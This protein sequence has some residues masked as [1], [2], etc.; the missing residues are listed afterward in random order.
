MARVANA[1]WSK[2]VLRTNLGI[3]GAAAYRQ[4][5]IEL[6]S[7]SA[8]DRTSVQRMASLA[9][10]T[11]Q[12]AATPVSGCAGLWRRVKTKLCSILALFGSFAIATHAVAA[13]L[14]L[15]LDQVP[16]FRVYS[17]NEGLNQKTVLAVEQD[18]DG[19]LWIATFGG[20]NRF[21]GSTFE[22]YTTRDGLRQNLIQGLLVDSSNRVWAGDAAGG[23]TVLENGRV[24]RVFEPDG[25]DRGVVRALEEVNGALYIALQP[26]GL[27]R[28]DLTELDGQIMRVAGA[29]NE[30]MALAY[31]PRDGFYLLSTDGLHRYDPTASQPFTHIDDDVST[32]SRDA[33]GNVFVGDANGRVGSVTGKGQ[34]A[35]FDR[36]FDARITGLI[37]RRGQV[38]WVFVDAL[39]MF[40][41]DDPEAAPYMVDSNGMSALY[42]QEGTL[43]V[44]G[45]QGLARYL[46]AR[47]KHYS[48]S[49]DG[50][51]PEVFSIVPDPQGGFWFGTNEGLIAVDA[52]GT[53]TN[54]S[55][56]LGVTRREVR[57]VVLSNDGETLW[58]GQI[59]GPT[60]AIDTT[61]REIRTTLGDENSLVV[62]ALVDADDRLWRGSYL[63]NLS[64]HDP[65]TGETKTHSISNG[66]AIYAMD[67][68]EDGVLWF[69]ASYQG[70]YRIDTR[71]AAAE[72]ELVLSVDKLEQEFFT[73]LVAE[74]S[75]EQ[76]VVWLAG[77][78][79]T[80]SRIENDVAESV[81]DDT[82]LSD[83][84]IYAI[85]PLPDDTIVLAT[86]RGA[87]R[88][89]S[90]RRTLEHYTSLDGFIAIEAKVHATYYDGGDN[91]LIGTTTGVTRMD[92][93]L[94]TAGVPVPTPLITRKAIGNQTD[95][96][97]ET[98]AAESDRGALPDADTIQV[99]YTA[100]SMRKPEAVVFSYRLQ[101]QDEE[102]SEATKTRSISYSNLQPGEYEFSVRA[103]IQG[104]TWSAPATWAFT[105]PTPFWR[106]PWFVVLAVAVFAMLV[107]TGIQWRLR[108]VARINHRL[109]E[110]VAARTRSIE[111]GRQQLEQIN[112]KLSSEIEEREKADE[113]RA[114]VEARFQQAYHNSPVG[115]ALVDTEGLVY[116]ANPK[117]RALFWPDSQRDRKEPLL[118]VVAEEDR[119]HFERFLADCVADRATETSMEVKCLAQSGKTRQIDFHPSAIR[120]SDGAL[121][122]LVLLANDVTES[123][124][125]TDKLAY[126]ARYDEL[127]GLIN[128]RAF[129][130]RLQS[131][132]EVDEDGND[133]Y[134]MFL[135]LDQ[136]KVVNDTCGHAAGDELLRTVSRLIAGCVRDDD[137]VARLGGD[138][139][140]LILHDCD[141][142]AAMRRAEHIREQVHKLE[143]LWK[144]DI[145]RIGV[146]IGVVLVGS[147]KRDLN[148][149]QQLADAACYAAKEAGRNRVHMVADQQDAAREH[150]GEM[151]WVQRLNHAIDTDSFEL[152]GQ[153]ILPL[154]N[155][156][157]KTER[158]E[159]LLRMR[160]RESSRL[161]LPGAFLP[162]AE[163]YGLQGRLDIWVVEHVIEA[164]QA[165]NPR[166]V[167]NRQFWV[168][169]SGA[170]V[171]DPKVADA[172]IQIVS[173]ADL[174]RG[175]LNFEITETAVIRKIT[176]AKRLISA[177][178]EMGC[179]FALDDFGSGL[180][181]FG[182]L[183]HLNVDGLKIDGQFVRDIVTDKTDRIFVK[184]IIDIAHTMNMSIVAEFVESDDI[185]STVRELGSD[186]AQGYGVH[187]PEPLDLMV[188]MTTAMRVAGL[189]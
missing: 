167:A 6:R 69:G 163:R 16:P 122:Y 99:E 42:D 133:A 108:A 115:M 59:Q 3:D 128:R 176:D 186:Y 119:Q 184:S 177:L 105:V 147:G 137:V 171:G 31:R 12:S 170:S 96:L 13:E 111:E 84:T 19:F 22:S 80:L 160:D 49:T 103:K 9:K 123:R 57:D 149:L 73:Q 66:A 168:N 159:I 164:L 97:T 155:Q 129:A 17:V 32:V 76:T 188:T 37:P 136:F 35:W 64:V 10:A 112:A 87:Y 61:S 102:W 179:R 51:E 113:L 104:G 165:Q 79:G 63:G 98:N 11:R 38:S 141:E 158:I 5:Q 140:G 138:E 94:Q 33:Q 150:R 36:Q 86:S 93:A 81:I 185:L 40:A 100:V 1:S 183:K 30:V 90:N 68:A 77:I 143:F 189:D 78:Q 134:L 161:I 175:V 88:Y 71:D 45:G 131:I 54:L 50:V 91:L 83:S 101:G 106:A 67:L 116:D 92:V 65:V 178:Q 124:A 43:W 142:A 39:G 174:P 95:M 162:A 135:D 25:E 8:G 62:S 72:P 28:L 107:W 34:I 21:N 14:E 4:R 60:V 58:F 145:F 53:L 132:A 144:Q 82:R 26:G 74:G 20:L 156:C 15:P 114:E 7:Q 172:L 117:M 27:R 85:Q 182:Y 120:A 109:R 70:L 151:R 139:F 153:R 110:E 180:S 187:R 146:S 2:G 18:Q 89:D 169:L 44:P 46:G 181:S 166:D 154:G 125:M 173:E 24:V 41:F 130:E 23:L 127:T 48:L 148:E 121:K 29:P 152:F 75:G 47:F 52:Q 55:D 126:Q 56:Q 157:T 118:D